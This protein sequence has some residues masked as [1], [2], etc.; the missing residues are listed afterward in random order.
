MTSVNRR[1]MLLVGSSVAIKMQRSISA[2]R[3]HPADPMILDGHWNKLEVHL[4]LRVFLSL[5][6][7]GRASH[8]TT[9]KNGGVPVSGRE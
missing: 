1:K 7:F 8:L 6:F 5:R 4:K 3:E 2:R 9:V